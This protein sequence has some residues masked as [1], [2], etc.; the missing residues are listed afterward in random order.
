MLYECI[1]QKCFVSTTRSME[2][3]LCYFWVVL[4]SQH[5]V[6]TIFLSLLPGVIMAR[7]EISVCSCQIYSIVVTCLLINA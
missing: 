6:L 5:A 7:F 4:T 3:Y 2:W 1:L